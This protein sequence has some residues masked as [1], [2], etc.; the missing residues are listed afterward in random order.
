MPM[1]NKYRDRFILKIDC[2]IGANR[3]VG[4]KRGRNWF[5]HCHQTVPISR[6]SLYHTIVLLLWGDA[7]TSYGCVGST[8]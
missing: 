1:K 6:Y 7:D 8:S 4:R 2:M 3:F 5:E